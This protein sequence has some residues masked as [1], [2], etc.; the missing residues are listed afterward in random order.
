MLRGDRKSTRLNSSHLGISYAVF[1][2]KKKHGTEGTVGTASM[3]YLLSTIA[4]AGGTARARA[5][6]A[7]PTS[8]VRRRTAS[9]KVLIIFFLRGATLADLS[10]SPPTRCSRH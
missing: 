2:L 6:E 3:A 9:R 5:R 7:R 1:C 8:L 10:P 4:D